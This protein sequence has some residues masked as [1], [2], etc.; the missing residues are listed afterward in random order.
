[1]RRGKLGGGGASVRSAT[2]AGRA[3]SSPTLRSSRTSSRRSPRHASPSVARRAPTT[4]SARRRW[5]TASVSVTSNTE[6]LRLVT[7]GSV[8]D[9]KSTPIGRPLF[10]SEQIIVGQSEHIEDAAR[11]RRRQYD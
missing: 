3:A 9:G 11:R 8:D 10:D 6:L 7:A 5:R 2:C 1:M 4:A